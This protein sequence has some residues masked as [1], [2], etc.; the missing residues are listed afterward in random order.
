M[1]ELTEREISLLRKCESEKD[2]KYTFKIIASINPDL[3]F[4]TKE[5]RELGYMRK[6]CSSCRTFFW[7]THEDRKVCGDPSCSGG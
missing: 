3:Y 1:S 7:T 6:Q 4:P 2:L 5:L